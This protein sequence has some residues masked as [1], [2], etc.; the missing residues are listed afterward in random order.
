MIVA[1]PK[2][3]KYYSGDEF[4][5]KFCEEEQCSF[6]KLSR[7]REASFRETLLRVYNF[8]RSPRIYLNFVHFVKVSMCDKSYTNLI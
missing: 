8:N 2:D 4:E 5:I 3:R 1:H 7:S 6:A